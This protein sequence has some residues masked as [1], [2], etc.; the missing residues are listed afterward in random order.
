MRAAFGARAVV[1]DEHDQRVVELSDGFE[2]VEEPAVLVI[3]MREEAGEDFHHARVELLFVRGQRVPHLDVG[4]VAREFRVF[5]DD[6]EFFLA[7]ERLFAIG[8]PTVVE[9][10]LV[11]VGPFLRDVMGRMPRAGTEIHEERLVG[12]DLL[13]VGDEPDRL[14]HEVYREVVA[15]FGR[16]RLVYRMVVVHEIWIPLIRIAAQEAVVAL[17]AAS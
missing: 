8:V 14:V 15:V 6:A 4:V 7:R 17:E 16:L 2:E 9:L 1:A 10:T 5:W 13:G 3:G 12:R 11:L